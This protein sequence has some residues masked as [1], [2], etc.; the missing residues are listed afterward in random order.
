MCK[1]QEGS[2][3]WV[4]QLCGLISDM[5]SV[6]VGVTSTQT[7]VRTHRRKAFTSL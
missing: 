3:Q 5:Q 7:T 2:V 4:M 6:H 1:E